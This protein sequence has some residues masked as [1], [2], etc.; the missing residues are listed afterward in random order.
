MESVKCKATQNDM[1]GLQSA[2]PATQNDLCHVI[3]HVEM[4]QRAMPA[5]RNEAMRRWKAPKVTP[6]AELAIGTAIWSSPGQLRT[7]A[8]GCATSGEHS[9]TPRTPE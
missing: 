2:A 3:E 8:N 1:G 9:S 4:S 6:F 7:V 5:T